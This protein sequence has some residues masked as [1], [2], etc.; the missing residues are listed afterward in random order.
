MRAVVITRHG[1]PEVLEV[2]DLPVPRAAPGQLVVEVAAAGVNF[3]DVYER[4][5]AGAYAAETP[6]VAGVEGAGTVHE[7]G[8]AVEGIA[9]GDR[10]AWVAAPGSYAE[11]VSVEAQ[12]AIPVPGGVSDEEAAAVLLQG[13]T[14]H[15]LAL[16]AYPVVEGDTVL[17]HAAAGGVGHLLTQVVKLRGGA[18]IATASTE[19]KAAF[20]RQS[21]ADHVI[22]YEDVASRVKELTGGKGVGAVFDGVGRATF[23]DSLAS[24]RPRGVMVL[25]GAASG[26]PPAVEIARLAA[27]SL[28]LTRPML[29]HYT[30]TSAELLERAGAVFGWVAEQRLRVAIGG[31]YRF[32]EARRA[33]EDL[34]SR[35][36]TGKLLL[37]PSG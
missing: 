19:E 6:L 25:Y 11:F 4:E 10:V 27:A 22:G 29:P 35:R 13:V 31:R 20:V 28:F 36:T 2:R 1:G 7:V 9:P 8:A 30:A 37:L 18:V 33:H 12:K 16:S 3:R 17:V 14:A 26:Q 24:L 5:G 34:Q 15:Y 21:G 32:A 23:D